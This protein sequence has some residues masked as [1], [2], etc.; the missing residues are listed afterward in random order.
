MS[1]IPFAIFLSPGGARDDPPPSPY[2]PQGGQRA[3]KKRNIRF[4]TVYQPQFAYIKLNLF[5]SRASSPRPRKVWRIPLRLIKCRLFARVP[6]LHPPPPRVMTITRS[7]YNG[8][9]RKLV[10]ALDIGTTY[11]GVCYAFLDPGVVP[12]AKPITT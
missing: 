6:L 3:G 10:F 2:F 11:S 4:R 5:P 7:P 8:P 12:E 9:S 1:W